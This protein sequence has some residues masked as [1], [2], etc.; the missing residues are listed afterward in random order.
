MTLFMG[1]G[2]GARGGLGHFFPPGKI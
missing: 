2:R 1:V